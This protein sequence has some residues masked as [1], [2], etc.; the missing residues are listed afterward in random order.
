MSED[1]EQYCELIKRLVPIEDLSLQLQNDVIQMAFV[2]KY[3]KKDF[4]FKQGDRDDYS[5]YILEG[6]LELIAD[7]QVKST[8]TSGTDSA[9]YALARLQPRQFSAKAKTDIAVLQLNR[10]VLD[11]LMVLEQEEKAK[12]IPDSE[13]MGVSDIVGEDTGDW[14]TKMLQSELFSRLPT[15]NIHKLFAL[16]EP[17]DFKAG[18]TVIRQGDVGENYYVIQGGRCEVSR[19]P[20]VTVLERRHCLPMQNAT[21]LLPC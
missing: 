18:D 9:R 4:V 6:Q 2:N 13:S 15:A 11:R 21:Q 17:V 14:M 3:K 12:E 1:K 7:K 16:L 20:S 10:S 5:F 19:A 8:I